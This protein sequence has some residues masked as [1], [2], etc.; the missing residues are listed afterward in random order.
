[1][2]AQHVTAREKIAVDRRLSHLVSNRPVLSRDNEWKEGAS[3]R[4]EGICDDPAAVG[5]AVRAATRF[6]V[7]VEN[8]DHGED[9]RDEPAPRKN[10][11]RLRGSQVAQDGQ[12]PPGIFEGLLKNGEMH[13][14]LSGQDLLMQTAASN[15][16]RGQRI[17]RRS[18]LN[19]GEGQQVI[20]RV[21][22]EIDATVWSLA[23]RSLLERFFIGLGPCA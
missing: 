23:H 11:Q 19:E 14:L 4:F 8:T 12:G 20:E 16:V 7:A 18:T 6:H 1:M 17:R 3:A 13:E 5:R 10:L 22:D 21:L 9:V 15:D 2:P